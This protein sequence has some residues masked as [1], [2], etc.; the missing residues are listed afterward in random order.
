MRLLRLSDLGDDGV[1]LVGCIVGVAANLELD[2]RGTTVLR[3]LTCMLGVERR[4]NV[5]DRRER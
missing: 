5:R 3:D 2:Q 1:D 4:P